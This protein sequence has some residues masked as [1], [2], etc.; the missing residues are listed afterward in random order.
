LAG[1]ASGGLMDMPVRPQACD[2]TMPW[3]VVSIDGT[4]LTGSYEGFITMIR[5]R[6][7]ADHLMSTAEVTIFNQDGRFTD[8]SK[9]K[10]YKTLEVSLGFRTTGLVKREKFITLQPKFVFPSEAAEYPMITLFGVSQEML[11]SRT[12]KRRTWKNMRESE[13]AEKIAAEYGWSADVQS[14]TTLLDEICQTSVTDWHMLD[15]MAR[16]HG[17]SLYVEKDVLHFHPPRFRNSRIKLMYAGAAQLS[18]FT[19]QGETLHSG[20][21]MHFSQIDPLKK[22]PFEVVS[23]EV[24]DAVTKAT[25]ANYGKPTKTAKEL[26]SYNDEQ[27]EHFLYEEGHEQTQEYLQRLTEG[28]SQHTRWL[29]QG[30][31]EVV[32]F[33]KV[34]PRDIIEILG[35]GKHSGE[36]YITDTEHLIENGAYMTSFHVARTWE[37]AG[38]G[39]SNTGKQTVDLPQVAS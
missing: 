14:T 26:A 15:K 7:A 24:E 34:K 4:P 38:Q 2:R 10:P 39:G 8:D 16:H 13:V 25:K 12:E 35:V 17:Y 6:E 29:M 30:T 9:F 33:E 5:V 32:G 36:Y 31:G 11:L 23:A 27:P 37:G 1:S 22:E 21:K 3:H 18:S 20:V 19:M 28:F